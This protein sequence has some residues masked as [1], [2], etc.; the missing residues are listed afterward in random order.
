MV[1]LNIFIRGLILILANGNLAFLC[2]LP[3]IAD[4]HAS[5]T[6]Y[7]QV[8]HIDCWTTVGRG[9]FEYSSEDGSACLRHCLHKCDWGSHSHHHGGWN[10]QWIF[11]DN[12][13]E[14]PSKSVVVPKGQNYIRVKDEM[15]L[16]HICWS[17]YYSCSQSYHTLSLTGGCYALK[18]VFSFQQ[19]VGVFLQITAIKS[20]PH[21]LSK[22]KLWTSFH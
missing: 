19:N 20:S 18:I 14:I 15:K 3:T 6:S 5:I 8:L 12:S 11:N 1:T 4:C 21:K 17:T 10:M 7:C 2:W 9:H 22:L 16:E 13:Q